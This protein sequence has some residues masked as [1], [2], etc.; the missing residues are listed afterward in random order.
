MDMI[1]GCFNILHAGRSIKHRPA[2]AT[3]LDDWSKIHMKMVDRAKEPT[4]VIPD[5]VED[6]LPN[7]QSFNLYVDTHLDVTELV[8]DF[9]KSNVHNKY[10]L[11][12]VDNFSGAL[13]DVVPVTAKVAH[14]AHRVIEVGSA[15]L[16]G[17]SQYGLG[18]LC[19]VLA[20][21]TPVR[22]QA[23]FIMIGGTKYFDG[24]GREFERILMLQ[25]A[26]VEETEKLTS[27][28]LSKFSSAIEEIE[29]W[30]F[31]PESV[32]RTAPSKVQSEEFATLETMVQSF[33]TLKTA[34][35]NIVDVSWIEKNTEKNKTAIEKAKATL[36][37]PLETD[38][39]KL[40]RH[41]AS[42]LLAR[43]I[44]SKPS[45]ADI[46]VAVFNAAHKY[47]K[48]FH[49]KD[50]QLPKLLQTKIK[51]MLACASAP[52][53]TP[54]QTGGSGASAIASASAV[55]STPVGARLKRQYRKL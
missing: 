55:V 46:D 6:P 23:I 21:A 1:H 41:L 42:M 32:L 14:V 50:A 37:D 11:S 43:V 40:A 51:E 3:Q 45:L 15:I 49:V 47:G 24:V 34:F 38:V 53:A 44:L 35:D 7:L 9:V 20:D 54:P 33:S 13:P 52:G 26:K 30:Q 39:P 16:E 10:F 5:G 22:E 18:Q 8:F 36:C 17:R 19:Q 4:I 2:D 25:C 28:S 29:A 12:T 48:T 31:P 27:T